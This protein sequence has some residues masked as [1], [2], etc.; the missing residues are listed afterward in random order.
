MVLTSD[1]SVPSRSAAGRS[2]LAGGLPRDLTLDVT[3]SSA[4]PAKLEIA[5][6]SLEPGRPGVEIVETHVSSLVF[7]GDLVHKRKKPVRFAFVD[8]STPERRAE[9]CRREV[10]L[11]RRFSPDIYLGVEDIVDDDG[12]VIDHAVLMRRLPPD[13]RLATLVRAGEDVS[14]CLNAVAR[15][16]AACHARASTSDEISAVGTPAAL[17]DLWERNLREMAVFVPGLLDASML[18]RIDVLAHRYLEARGPLLDERVARGRVVDGHGD[19]L[20]EDIFCL[21]DGPRILDCLEFDDRLRWGDVLYDIG[22]LAMDLERLGHPHLAFAFLDRYREYSGETHPR[23]LEHHYIAYRAL[24][25]AKISCLRGQYPRHRRGPRLS[26]SQCL[27]HLARRPGAARPH[28]WSARHRQD[29]ARERAR[30]RARMDGPA[31]RRGPQG[32]RRPRPAGARHG[33][34]SRQPVLLG[35]DGRDLPGAQIPPLV[36]CCAGESVVLDASFSTARSRVDVAAVAAESA[37]DLTELRCLLPADMAAQRLSRRAQAD[38]DAS[39]ATPAIANAMA[40]EFEPWP[41]ATPV[42]TLEPLEDVLPA[43][44]DQLDSPRTRRTSS[45]TAASGGRGSG[46]VS[47]GDPHLGR[48][49]PEPR[50]GRE[51][52]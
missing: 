9:V 26:W 43:I 27:R 6:R 38:R 1:R 46:A 8:L 17:R 50:R 52:C 31:L 16:M 5:A 44:L 35:D 18:A 42:G 10:T 20:A 11:N 49:R 12:R 15:E 23:S 2:A 39:D 25:R 19:L 22:F 51:R 32:A 30:R 21:D 3:T 47:E 40:R 13:R 24:V 34:L 7:V 48:R 33:A 4:R 41:T 28:R 14:R 45:A 37:A 29:D 36:C